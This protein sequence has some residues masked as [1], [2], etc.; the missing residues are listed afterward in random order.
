[1]CFLKAAIFGLAS[2]GKRF[3]IYIG[4]VVVV[5]A[6]FHDGDQVDNIE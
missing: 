6:L 5:K 4:V 3:Q 1:M 2:Y